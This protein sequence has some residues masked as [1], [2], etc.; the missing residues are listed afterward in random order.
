MQGPAF[1]KTRAAVKTGQASSCWT[2][3]GKIIVKLNNDK[4]ITIRSEEDVNKLSATGKPR[5]PS[6]AAAAACNAD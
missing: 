1:K 5:H 4:K 2:Y 6:Y 3:D